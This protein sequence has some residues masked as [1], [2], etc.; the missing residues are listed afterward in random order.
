MAEPARLVGEVPVLGSGSGSGTPDR[1]AEVAA[2]GA[3]VAHR[4]EVLWRSLP[5]SLPCPVGYGVEL[6][7]LADSPVGP[8]VLRGLG[9]RP[10]GA[11][12]SHG[13]HGAHGR[14]GAPS[15][16][17]PAGT[18]GTTPTQ[19]ERTRDGPGFAGLAP[20]NHAVATAERPPMREIREYAEREAA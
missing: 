18:A 1:T 6:G 10:A 16:S 17:A 4:D 15:A 14:Q 8:P 3:R 5:E 2:A 12:H 11:S 7:L 20:R 9:G 19:C 13:R